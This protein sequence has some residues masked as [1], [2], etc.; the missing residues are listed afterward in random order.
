MEKK[1]F[2]VENTEEVSNEF[3]SLQKLFQ[4]NENLKQT[5]AN[6]VKRLFIIENQQNHGVETSEQIAMNERMK[7]VEETT[8]INIESIGDLDLKFQLHENSVNDSHLIW[9]INNFQQRTT[10][11][12]IGKTRALHSAP[13]FTSKMAFPK[14]NQIHFDQSRRPK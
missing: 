9:K 10:D 7:S 6:L 11:A 8:R 1:K 3:E 2:C 12:V 13:C 5:V 4:E 14:E